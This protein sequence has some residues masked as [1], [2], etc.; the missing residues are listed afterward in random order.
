MYNTR[1]GGRQGRDMARSLRLFALVLHFL[2]HEQP[3]R[4]LLAEASFPTHRFENRMNIVE[5]RVEESLVLKH[6][7]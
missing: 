3:L 5:H 1:Q 2:A 7:V 4:T 6:N